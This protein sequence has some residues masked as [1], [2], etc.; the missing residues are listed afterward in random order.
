[1]NA[2]TQALA[3]S[4]RMNLAL[5]FVLL[6]ALIG[7]E[8]ALLTHFS[9]TDDQSIREA[10]PFESFAGDIQFYLFRLGVSLV[11]ALALFAYVHYDEPLAA[12]NAAGRA[13]PIRWHWLLLNIALAVSAALL[14]GL[15]YLQPAASTLFPWIAISWRVCALAAALAAAAAL[16]PRQAWLRAAR[17]LGSLWLYAGVAAVAAVASLRSSE[18]LWE[19]SAAV[20]MRLVAWVLGPVLPGLQ[21]D[22]EHLLLSTPRFAVNVGEL[23]SGLEGLALVLVF[24]IAWLVLLRDE[25]RWPRALILIPLGMLLSYALNV[26][27]LAVLM[28]IGDAG[29]SEAAIYGF[30]SQAG[31]IG[32]NLVSCAIALVSRRSRWLNHRAH[33]A[34][35]ADASN[36]TAAYLLP[37]LAILVAGVVSKAGLPGFEKLYGL[38]LL[39]ALLALAAYRRSFTTLNWHFT[40]RGPLIGV[41]VC[42][43][44]LVGAHFLIARSD[45]PAELLAMPPT[46]RALWIAARIAAAVIT[47]PIAEELAFRGFLMRRLLSAEFEHVPFRSVGIVPLLISS[48]AFGALHGALWPLAIV[49]GLAYGFVLIRTQAIGE[50]MAA[51]ATTNALLAAC[52]VAG[53]QW[54]LW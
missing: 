11:L 38:R 37:F 16:A 2:P 47:V 20:T 33:E 42:A 23:C 44:W 21:T 46:A 12:A 40:W 28:M 49:A 29:Y 17:A 41:A 45:A 10:H 54:E 19:R 39:A 43:L 7:L 13:H 5:R 51:H 24:C 14:A 4:G 22:P 34:A 3:L 27:R 30:H 32:F 8:K 26:I 35:A 18:T 36:P 25:Y 52:V 15:I 9:H 48:I 53:G 31:W 6:A 1:M 50:A